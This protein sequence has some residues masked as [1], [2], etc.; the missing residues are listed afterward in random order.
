M[1]EWAS[2]L[3][4]SRACVLLIAGCLR[5]QACLDAQGQAGW[6]GGQASAHTGKQLRSTCLCDWL[7]LALSKQTVAMTQHPHK[8]VKRAKRLP[9]QKAACPGRNTA[10]DAGPRDHGP[11]AHHWHAQLRAAWSRRWR[12]SAMR[13]TGVRGELSKSPESG[14]QP[15]PVLP[16]PRIW[17][18]PVQALR[19]HPAC[20][21][22]RRLSAHADGRPHAGTGGAGTPRDKTST[23]GQRTSTQRAESEREPTL[24][25]CW[26]APAP[27]AAQAPGAPVLR[28][29]WVVAHGLPSTTALPMPGVAM[30]CL[31]KSSALKSRP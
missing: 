18:C 15:H 1:L 12:K 28:R 3:S 9:G 7:A 24:G 11:L 23:P 22:Q 5:V 20:L 2:T 30:H 27:S 10:G 25:P 14:S 19:R 26:P 8:Q 13:C 29:R 6:Q 31:P 4:R 21:C 16:A 17:P